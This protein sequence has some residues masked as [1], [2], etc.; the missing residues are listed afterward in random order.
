MRVILGFLLIYFLF[1][2]EPGQPNVFNLVHQKV[3]MEMQKK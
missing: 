1:H 2:N 3:I